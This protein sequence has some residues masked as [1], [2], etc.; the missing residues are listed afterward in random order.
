MARLGI[1]EL[2]NKTILSQLNDKHRQHPTIYPSIQPV[3]V[4][5]IHDFNDDDDFGSL[6]DDDMKTIIYLRLFK[7]G[8]LRPYDQNS[9]SASQRSTKYSRT[10]PKTDIKMFENSL[11]NNY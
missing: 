10:I 5:K 2:S 11:I 9:M 7:S 3:E 8:R 1:S 6:A 4:Q